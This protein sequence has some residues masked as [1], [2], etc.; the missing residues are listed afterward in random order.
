[1]NTEAIS[2]TDSAHIISCEAATSSLTS[3][4]ASSQS[5]NGLIIAIQAC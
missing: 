4:N 5:K 3:T 2:Y 1:M